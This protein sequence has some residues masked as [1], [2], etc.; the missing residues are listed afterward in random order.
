MSKSL[1]MAMS[2]MAA[3]WA[4]S[5]YWSPYQSCTRALEAENVAR[6]IKPVVASSDAALDCARWL[7]AN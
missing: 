1:T 5:I 3:C 4:A 7:K 2:L 6:G